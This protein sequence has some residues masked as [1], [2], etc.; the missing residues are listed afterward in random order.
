MKSLFTTLLLLSAVFVQAQTTVDFEEFSLTTEGF[1]NGDDM[2][3]GFTSGN[4]F[5]P[6]V[7]NATYF[8]WSGWAISNTTDVTTPGFTNQYSAISG[9]GYEQSSNYAVS[10]VSGESQV[11]LEGMAAGEVVNGFYVNNNTYAYLSMKNGDPYAKKFGGLTGDDPDFFLL[12]IKRLGQADSLQFTLSSSDNGTFGMNTPAYFC[13]DN[14][15]TSDG[16]TSIKDLPKLDI[17]VFPNPTTDFVNIAN[18]SNELLDYKIFSTTGQLLDS[19]TTYSSINFQSLTAGSYILEVTDGSK[20]A[21][22]MI[23]RQ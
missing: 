19:G 18:P 4:A 11:K 12:T 2:A 14:L 9:S 7:Y 10:F 21:R 17:S 6:N 1:L 8:F 23:F 15:I 22:E 13:M 3:G 20:V 16:V 5:L